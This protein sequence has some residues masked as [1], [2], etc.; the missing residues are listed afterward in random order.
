MKTKVILIGGFPEIIELCEE[1]NYSIVGIID[2]NLKD[3]FLGYKVFGSDKIAKEV[4]EDY[5][6]IPV[7][8]TPD[9][10]VVRKKL[11]DFY[12]GLGFNFCNLISPKASISKS[13]VLGVGVVVQNGVNISYNVKIGNFVKINTFSN[14]MHDSIINDYTTVAPNAVILGRVKIGS[15][16]YIGA[17]STILPM[18]EI[19]D[20]AVIGAGAVVTKNIPVSITVTGNP[21]KELK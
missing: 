14:I 5:K 20:N 13:S 9:I 6:N 19:G 12:S 4:Y 18:K 8:I 17:N 11:V 16:C 1:C 2:N 10:P 3:N 21:A 7:I 15:C